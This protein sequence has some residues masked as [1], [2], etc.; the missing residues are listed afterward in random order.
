MS[1]YNRERLFSKMMLEIRDCMIYL[2]PRLMTPNWGQPEPV[3]SEER[4][5]NPDTM[6]I[7]LND[8]IEQ[9]WH[10]YELK[11]EHWCELSASYAAYYSNNFFPAD[12][13]GNF[14]EGKIE[15][16]KDLFTIYLRQA[17]HF[18]YCRFS[19][20]GKKYTVDGYRKALKESNVCRNF[21]KSNRSQWI[22]LDE[23]VLGEP[24]FKE[25]DE[26][27][28][29]Y[30]LGNLIADHQV[31][32]KTLKKDF[33]KMG[34]LFMENLRWIKFRKENCLE[35]MGKYIHSV[36]VLK[37][38]EMSKKEIFRQLALKRITM[39]EGQSNF[40]PYTIHGCANAWQVMAYVNNLIPGIFTKSPKEFAEAVLEKVPNVRKYYQNKINHKYGSSLTY[41]EERKKLRRKEEVKLRCY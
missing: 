15:R 4:G 7:V 22:E 19:N 6:R 33:P 24:K 8:K 23:I 31:F 3:G 20:P 36:A 35:T 34:E 18:E 14:A 39:Y 2:T 10:R 5:V 1:Y 32:F 21:E 12:M 30:F 40:S 9:L 38:L 41:N 13:F 26:K 29:G 37:E 17:W 16:K 25:F 27:F 28:A 11:P